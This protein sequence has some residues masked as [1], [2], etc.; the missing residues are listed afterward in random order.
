MGTA[1]TMISFQTKNGSVRVAE[2]AVM[3]VL[4]Q[5]DKA[6]H[7]TATV[8]D[9]IRLRSQSVGD[10][11]PASFPEGF[12]LEFAAV[13]QLGAWENQGLEHHIDCGLPSFSEAAS[14]LCRRA[15]RNRASLEG[16][17][18]AILHRRVLE[19]WLDQIAWQGPNELGAEFAIAHADEEAFLD[20]AAEF[21][22]TRRHDF[23]NLL[24][25]EDK[26]Q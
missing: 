11:F 14:D 20:A 23:T 7:L 22:W 24:P 2:C 26:E 4:Q 5:A 17:E 1:R 18:S 21:L 3:A 25:A 13:A 6:A 12:L 10:S 15:E 19:F 8:L 16:R 9:L